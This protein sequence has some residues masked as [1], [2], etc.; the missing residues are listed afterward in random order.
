MK[1]KIPFESIQKSI[2]L[3]LL[4]VI[5]I[6]VSAQQDTLYYNS[7]WKPTVKD[8]ATFFRPPIQK[9]G[10]LFRIQDYFMSGQLQMN[11]LSKSS[12][13]DFWEGKVTWYNE[14]GSVFQEGTYIDNRLE[15]EFITY[16]DAK[17]LVS[18]YAN[19]RFVSG[20]RNTPY[21][22]NSQMYFEQEGDTL[23]EVLY[24]KDIKGIRSEHYG[25]KERYRFLSKYYNANGELIGERKLLPNNYYKGIEVLYYYGPMRVKEIAFSPFGQQLISSTYYPNGQVREEVRQE[26]AWSKTYYSVD[27][28]V[29]GKI[30]YQL[31]RDRLNPFDGTQIFFKYEKSRKIHV[32]QKVTTYENGEI[33]REE[34]RH[35]NGQISSETTYKNSSRELQVSYDEIGNEIARMLYKGYRPFQGKEINAGGTATYDQGKL[36]ESV[37]YYHNT[38]LVKVKKSDLLETYYNMEG[39]VLGEL[40]LIDDNGY[41]KA[42][43]GQ[44]FSMDYTNKGNI[45][46]I[47]EFR[48]GARV[49]MTSFRKRLVGKDN[50]KTFKKIEEYDS[51]GYTRT[52]EIK[53]YSNG[54]KQSEIVYKNYSEIS[55]AFY[56]E[57]E[58]LLGTYDYKK[59]EGILYKFFGDSDKLELMEEVKEGKMIRLKKYNYGKSSEYGQINPILEEDV[60]INCCAAYYNIEGELIAK[61]KFK[62]QLPWEGMA[63]DPSARTRYEVKAGKRNGTYEKLDYYQKVLEEGQFIDDKQEGTFKYYDYQGN[64]QKTENFTTGQLNGQA[65]YYDTKGKVLYQMEYKKGLPEN[66][67]R[68]MTYSYGKEPN[69]ETYKDGVLV[70]S[71]TYDKN[72]KSITKYTEGK[73]SET[74]SY[75][76]DSNKK[77]LSYGLTNSTLD[78]T[79]IRYDSEGKEQHRANVLKGK[80]VSGTLFLTPRYGDNSVMFIELSKEAEILKVKFTDIENRVIFKAEETV[81]VGSRVIYMDKLGLSL[82]YLN[83]RDLY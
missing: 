35:E 27:G 7:K 78:G 30:T 57:K 70:E 36:I 47:E 64:L 58:Q 18:K 14:D 45:A 6:S 52:K 10:E 67:T 61:L 69:Q 25:T 43:E 21:G 63:Y 71:I 65:V 31:D 59:K 66:G 23:Y 5:N 56:D 1:Q 37:T 19:G 46:S 50:Y 77:R 26:P 83:V 79:I 12:E 33:V 68:N 8:S 48:E 44:R 29:L 62:N 55:G 82:D 34:L 40:K 24:E 17:R 49:Q 41:P 15:G 2:I 28:K 51:E 74:I 22:N 75:Y 11:A 73:N 20:R 81:V 3:F 42:F 16:M 72:G 4:I 39:K 38:K 9:E 60:D 80:L 54:S 32:I 76:K 13:K 53:F